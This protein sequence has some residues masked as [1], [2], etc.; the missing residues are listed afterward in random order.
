[1]T[2]VSTGGHSSPLPRNSI[3][4]TGARKPIIAEY[5][6]GRSGSRRIGSETSFAARPKTKLKMPTF[7]RYAELE[8]CPEGTIAACGECASSSLGFIAGAET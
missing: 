6:I 2:V 1:M 4:M 5:R 3:A 7:G 8:E